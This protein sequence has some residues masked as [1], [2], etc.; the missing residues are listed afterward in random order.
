MRGGQQHRQLFA[1][2]TGVR[3]TA[4]DADRAG[5]AEAL[6]PPLLTG[7]LNGG[8]NGT[9]PPAPRARSACGALPGGCSAGGT[10]DTPGLAM[11]IFALPTRQDPLW[12]TRKRR[13]HEAAKIC[14][15]DLHG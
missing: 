1:Q 4:V 6:D 8:S 15:C 5:Q 2:G 7:H 3:Q 14:E 11:I 13:L 9:A 12:E 10:A